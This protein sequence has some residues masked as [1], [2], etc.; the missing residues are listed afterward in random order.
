MQEIRVDKN[1]K[2]WETL[3]SD[4][5]QKELVPDNITQIGKTHGGQQSNKIEF[6]TEV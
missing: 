6:Y 2:T 1:E 4:D 3:E 5:I